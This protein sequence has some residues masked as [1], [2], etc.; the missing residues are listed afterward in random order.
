M[1]EKDYGKVFHSWKFKEYQEHQ[2]GLLWHIL[3]FAVGGGTALYSII[4]KN[5]LFLFIIL[6]LW[7]V[8]FITTRRQPLLLTFSI[9]EDGV[10][11]DNK[12][13]SY[14]TLKEFWIIYNPLESK[15]LYLSFQSDFRPDLVIPLENTNPVKVRE[16]LLEYLPEDVE[17]NE[18]SASEIM[19]REYKL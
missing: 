15:Y 16:T 2:R 12:L 1:A 7:I 11:V 10:A 18:E 17:R 8:I 9:A 19:S 13:Y 5:W 14:D 6:T 3:F 4:V